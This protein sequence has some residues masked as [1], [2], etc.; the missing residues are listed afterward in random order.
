MRL[1]NKFCCMGAL[2]GL[3]LAAPGLAFAD[4]SAVCKNK[5]KAIE[6]EIEAAK[7]AGKLDELPGLE[8]ALAETKANCQ[9][10]VVMSKAELKLQEKEL[11]V[12]KAELELK[13]AQASGKADKIAKKE[14]KLEQ[15]KLELKEAQEAMELL[16]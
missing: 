9:G 6:A 16:K 8:A 2:L 7:A 3:C 4:D 1:I 5:E 10:D 15:A 13:E 11:K 14:L 12:Q